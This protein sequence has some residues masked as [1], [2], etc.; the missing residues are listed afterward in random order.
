MAG[1]VVRHALLIRVHDPAFAAGRRQRTTDRL[2]E[3]GHVDVVLAERAAISAAS[4]ARLARSAPM[5]PRSGWRP[6][7]GPTFGPIFTLRMW[8]LRIASRPLM[9]G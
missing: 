5:P 3:V 1:L 7:A 9:S 8:T 4:F 6:G 2:L